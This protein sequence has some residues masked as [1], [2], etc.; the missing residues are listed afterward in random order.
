MILLNHQLRYFR[1]RPRLVSQLRLP[2]KS[3]CTHP[4]SQVRHHQVYPERAT[5][6]RPGPGLVLSYISPI[7]HI[8]AA[9]G[10]MQQQYADDTQ[11]YVANSHLNRDTALASS[12][13]GV[14][15]NYIFGFAGTVFHST[16]TKQS[17]YYLELPCIQ[18]SWRRTGQKSYLRLPHFSCFQIMFLPHSGAQ[19]YT[20]S[21]HRRCCQNGRLLPCRQSPRLRKLGA[22]RHLSEKLGSSS[23]YSVKTRSRRNNATRTNQH[24]R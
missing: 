13:R 15:T 24:L 23:S 19:P 16:M 14:L 11:L 5:R 12:W 17:K 3:I 4:I 22:L 18:D 21:T 6:L 9:H 1:L 10:L 8:A 7:A 20:T 2:Q